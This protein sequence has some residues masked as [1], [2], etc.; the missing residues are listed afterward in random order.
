MNHHLKI[1][2]E[3]FCLRSDK[4][5]KT[6]QDG[7]RADGEIETDTVCGCAENFGAITTLLKQLE[8]I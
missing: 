5:G 7:F 1:R 6:H 2:I 3:R 4:L 8:Y